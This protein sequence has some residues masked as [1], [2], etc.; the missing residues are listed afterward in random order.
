MVLL[1]LHCDVC[2]GAGLSDRLTFISGTLGKAFGVYGGYVAGDA[3][4]MDAV[5]SF[6]PGFIFTTAIPPTVAA[7]ALAS[8]RYLKRSTAERDRHQV[9]V[10]DP[11]SDNVC[12]GVT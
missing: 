5:R 1:T 4:L 12:H 11:P 10:G 6:A 3:T 8:V 7:G 9:A 2:G